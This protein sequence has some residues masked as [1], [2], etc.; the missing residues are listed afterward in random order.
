VALEHHESE[1]KVGY[2]KLVKKRAVDLFS[3]I[4]KI[5]DVFDAMTTSRPYRKHNFSKEEALS[6]MLEKGKDEF[7]PII[8]KLFSDM[9]GICPIGSLILMDTSEIGVVFEKNPESK[10]IMRPKVKLV[11]DENGNK[12]DGQIVDLTEKDEQGNYKRSI[13]KT[14]DQRK[15]DIKTADY[16]VAEAE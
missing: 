7:D 16:F 1:G 12:I 2:P 3:K 4:V 5:V 9:V 15:Y 11:S 8:L 13:I 6:Y 14:L 10:F